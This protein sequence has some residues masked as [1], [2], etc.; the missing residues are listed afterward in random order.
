MTKFFLLFL[1][2]FLITHAKDV[3]NE[4]E[5]SGFGIR[6]MIKELDDHPTHVPVQAPVIPDDV[7]SSRR[8]LGS[9]LNGEQYCESKD[10]LTN[11]EAC[12]ASTCCHW[13]TWE[14]GEASNFGKG[15]C[16][17]S[18]IKDVCTDMPKVTT[19]KVHHGKDRH[20]GDIGSCGKYSSHESIKNACSA[21]SACIGYTIRNSFGHVHPW[22]LKSPSSKK[23]GTSHDH[24]F[25]Q[26]MVNYPQNC[27][28]AMEYGYLGAGNN[29]H[30]YPKS[31]SFEEISSI[32]LKDNRCKGFTTNN[33]GWWLK[34]VTRAHREKEGESHWKFWIKGN[35]CDTC[36]KIEMTG[37]HYPQM[38][39]TYTRAH[40]NFN[41]YPVWVHESRRNYIYMYYTGHWI[42]NHIPHSLTNEWK[43]SDVTETAWSPT[44]YEAKWEEDEVVRCV[45]YN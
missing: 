34:T 45:Q 12:K 13:N 32:C 23:M 28:F 41:G 42:L 18:I 11:E 9:M 15:R 17:S 35:S 3:E 7:N 16:W 20:G 30:W 43:A 25:Y 14:E 5:L 38:S 33:D 21:N 29:L 31:K 2:A 27:D 26:K 44:P 39:G 24:V 19:Y 10:M 1:F 4:T 36:I 8:N 6:R 37:N 22:C 40:K